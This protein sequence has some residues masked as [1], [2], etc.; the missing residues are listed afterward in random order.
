VAATKIHFEEQA[1]VVGINKSKQADKAVRPA[2]FVLG[3]QLALV[4][5]SGF[6]TNY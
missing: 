5:Q 6:L 2:C 1:P 3:R 4:L